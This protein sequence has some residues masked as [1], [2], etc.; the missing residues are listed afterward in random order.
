MAR[1]A[2]N[3]AVLGISG[4]VFLAPLGRDRMARALPEEPAVSHS[5]GRKAACAAERPGSATRPSVNDG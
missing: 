4:K 1:K 2:Y 3:T 5:T